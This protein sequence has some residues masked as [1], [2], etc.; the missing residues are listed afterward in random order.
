MP[1]ARVKG[2]APWDTVA[3]LVGHKESWSGGA[4]VLR[5][6]FTSPGE[7]VALFRV[8]STDDDFQQHYFMVVAKVHQGMVVK[9]DG[10]TVPFRTP[11]VK[12]SVAGVAQVLQEGG[13]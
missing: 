2:E 5:E 8:F 3:R 10:A 4:Y 13:A 12:R 7:Q 11:A 1:H 9:L 6:V